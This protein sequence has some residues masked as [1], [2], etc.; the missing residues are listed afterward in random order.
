MKQPSHVA[1][2]HKAGIEMA[3]S[4]ENISSPVG[5]AEQL[6]L[7]PMFLTTRYYLLSIFGG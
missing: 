6:L 4:A 1:F 7:G 5:S 2:V 3:I